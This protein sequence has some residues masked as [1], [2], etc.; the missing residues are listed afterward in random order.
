[1]PSP[2]LS[3]A[4][5]LIAAACLL[6]LV[7]GAWFGLVAARSSHPT[8]ADG[9][10]AVRDTVFDLLRAERRRADSLDVRGHGLYQEMRVY[11]LAADQF[12]RR[13]MLAEGRLNAEKAACGS[14]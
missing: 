13:T 7:S 5:R 4:R 12:A 2:L 10:T 9:V 8:W 1:M 6:F 11:M 14:W 3:Q